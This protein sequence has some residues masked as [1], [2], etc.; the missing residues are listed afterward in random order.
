[1]SIDS[2]L[3]YIHSVCWKGSVL[4]LDRIRELMA[5]LG[6][7]ERELKFV[8][9]AGTNGKGSTCACVSSV[10][11][12]AGYRTGLFTSP[13]IIKFNERIQIDGEYI[14]DD[15]LEEIT[16]CVRPH[17][18]AMKDSPTEFELITGIALEYFRRKKCDIVVLEVG[19]G[20][21]LDSTNVIPTAEVEVITSIGLDHTQQLGDTVE[22]VAAA[23]AGIIKPNTDVVISGGDERANAVIRQVCERQNSSLK[24]VDRDRLAVKSESLEGIAFDYDT[25][26]DLNI[27][28]AGTYQPVNAATAILAIE[29]LQKRGW[30]IS[31]AD[32][33]NGISKV[34]WPGRFEILH[35][36]PYLILDGAHNPHG[37]K[38]TVE[39]MKTHFKGEKGV[40]I[41]GAMAD[42]DIVA[43]VELL[44][45]IAG[46]VITVTPDNPRAMTSDKL[47][48]VIN[49]LGCEA[50]SAEDIDS[51]LKRGFELSEDYAF[52]CALG[53]LYFSADVRNGAEKLFSLV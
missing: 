36:N 35:K 49:S 27:S 22:A 9:V 32:I 11:R 2:T 30:K 33:K 26:T 17:A 16:A 18:E 20:G 31:E 51:A 3:E 53:S 19:L 13:Y 14:S 38:A 1:M 5:R 7:P 8:H 4:G 37:M 10:L 42:K 24:I 48:K 45:P 25:H 43:M 44:R 6:N 46:K 50:E 52:I 12:E 15:D 41:M 23:K 21:E 47:A 28:L 39:S 40:I 29:V 34:K